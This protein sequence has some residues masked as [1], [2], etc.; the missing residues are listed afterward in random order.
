M[1]GALEAPSTRLDSVDSS[2]SALAVA[3]AAAAAAAAAVLSFNATTAFV[4]IVRLMSA[5]ITFCVAQLERMEPASR[6]ERAEC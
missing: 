3:V 1:Q 6:I 4:I 5:M 2:Q